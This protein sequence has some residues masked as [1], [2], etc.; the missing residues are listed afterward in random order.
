MILVNFSK[1]IITLMDKKLSKYLT[2]PVA[3]FIVLDGEGG[4]KGDSDI[5]L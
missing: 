1:K 3:K 2:N 5:G 4:D